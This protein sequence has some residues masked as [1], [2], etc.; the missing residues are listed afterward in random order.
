MV[1]QN[2]SEFLMLKARTALQKHEYDMKSALL[3]DYM[4]SPARALRIPDPKS[5][6]QT[7]RWIQQT[8]NPSSLKTGS[9]SREADIKPHEESRM[10]PG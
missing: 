8:Y 2:D 10:W 6:L 7:G 4:T 9:A 1:S 5:A 3:R